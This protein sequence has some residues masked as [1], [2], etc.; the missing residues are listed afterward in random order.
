MNN[1]ELELKVK[2]LLAIDNFFDMI[3]AV[4]D[5]EKEYK[6]SDFFKVTKMPLIDVIKYAKMWYVINLNSVTAQIQNIINSLDFGNISG[7][8][9]QLGDVYAKENAD[10]L[11]ILSSFKDI[12]K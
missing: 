7:I 6:N 12:V 8:L 10:T 9:D 11:S 2:E 4:K 3:I 5:F 1:Q